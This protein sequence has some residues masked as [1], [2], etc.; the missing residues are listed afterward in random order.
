MTSQAATTTTTAAAAAAWTREDDKAFENALAACAAP[1]PADGGAPDDDWF[2]ALAASVPG[3]R[4]AEEVRRHYEALVEDVAAIDAGR[5]PLPRYAGEESAAPP[6][7][8]GAAAAA[9]KDGGH[10]RDERKGGGGGYDGGKSC[11][12]AEQER[13][14]GIPWTEEEHST[15][16][17]GIK[18]SS[19]CSRP[20]SSE[21]LDCES[22]AASRLDGDG[23]VRASCTCWAWT[24]SA[25]GTPGPSRATSSSRGAQRRFRRDAQKYFIR[26]KSMERDR[27]GSSIHDI[28][29]VTA[30]DQ[31]AAQQGAPIT[32]PPGHGQPRGGGAGPAGHE[33]PPP[34]PPGRRAAAHAHVQRRAHGPPRR[35]P[36]GA[37]R[38]RHAGGVPAGPRAVRRARRLPGAT[39]QDAPMTRHGRT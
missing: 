14:K 19:C 13:R 8:A 29:S 7:G 23:I 20:S 10:R 39:G 11:S 33:A 35:R 24:S 5:V 9:S 16:D 31:V 26:L 15:R 32:G 30:G 4:S 18:T 3:A 37:R 25:T 28:T 1:P 12:K 22:M 27:R 17:S 2:A 6:D 36:H 21:Q 34:P 38:R